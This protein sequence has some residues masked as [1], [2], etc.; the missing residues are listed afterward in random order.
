MNRLLTS[1]ALAAFAWVAAPV[2]TAAPIASEPF[3]YTA[4]S[5]ATASG[6]SGWTTNWAGGSTNVTAPGL[7]L[8]LVGTPATNKLTTN[9]DNNGAFRSLPSQGTDGTTVWLAYL[10]SGTG[11]PVAGGYAGVSLFAGGT[12]NLFTGKR[13]NQTVWGTERSGGAGGDST[14]PA[15]TATHLLVY[16]IDF[17]A[18]TTAGNEKVTMYVDPAPGAAPNVPAAVT[19][20]DITNFTFDRVRIQS[21]N[22]SSFNADEVAIGTTYADVVAPEPATAALL[23]LAAAA[24]LLRRRRRI[25][26]DLR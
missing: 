14:V 17:G 18:G 19:L 7:T 12:E 22:G 3:G 1:T 15:D 8:G 2:S 6:G 4:G 24:T 26:G 16:R 20:N 25:A 11:A 21:G 9:N 23:G 13:S 5:L 10:A